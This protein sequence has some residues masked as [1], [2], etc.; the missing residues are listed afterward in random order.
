MT[1]SQ[2]PLSVF[3]RISKEHKHQQLNESLSYKDKD[4]SY[5]DK[6]KRYLSKCEERV[7][8]DNKNS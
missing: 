1:S 4:S 8:D 2:L 7:S 5:S 3:D 6:D